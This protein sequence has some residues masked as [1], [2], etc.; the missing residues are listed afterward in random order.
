[1]YYNSFFAFTLNS[2]CITYNS[3]FLV[4]QKLLIVSSEIVVF[5]WME[6]VHWGHSVFMWCFFVIFRRNFSGVNIIHLVL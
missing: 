3:T 6:Y 5:V 2:C 1:M 4:F